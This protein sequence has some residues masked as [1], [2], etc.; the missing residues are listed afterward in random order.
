MSNAQGYEAAANLQMPVCRFI[1]FLKGN[2]AKFGVSSPDLFGKILRGSCA[3]SA[4]PGVG[5][6]TAS[7]RSRIP[8]TH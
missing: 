3:E 2:W 5:L 8:H 4:L 1:V 6:G 7:S